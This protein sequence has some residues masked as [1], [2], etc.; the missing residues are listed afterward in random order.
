MPASISEFVYTLL[1]IVTLA[2]YLLGVKDWPLALRTRIRPGIAIIGGLFGLSLGAAYLF[3][4]RG[5]VLSWRFWVEIA[6]C[7]W[8]LAGALIV[9]LAVRR[10]LLAFARLLHER[11]QFAPGVRILLCQALPL[12]LFVLF[13]LPYA[14]AFA[15]V[16]RFKMPIL[17]DP[18]RVWQREF[19]EI[20][21][22]S[23]DGTSLRGW[24][25]PAKPLTSRPEE[26][27]RTLIVC[28]GIAA[29]R[30]LML[31]F[32]EA[33]D[34]LDANVLMFDLR[35]HGESGG[36]S[37]TLGCKEKD[38]V[39]AA[40]AYARRERP[41][42]SKQVI[43]MGVSL[44]AA[45]MAEAAPLAEPPLDAVI[46]D[47][48]FASTADMTHSVLRVFPSCTHPWLLTLGLPMA[49]WHAGCPMMAVR[50][51]ESIRKLRSP[52]LLLHSRGDPLIP[53]EHG[54]R[55]YAN[56]PEPKRLCVFEL[57]GHCDGFFAA[58]ER[59]RAEVMAICA[60]PG[61]CER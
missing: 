54:M 30:S 17:T 9:L 2:V 5:V 59:Y 52:V 7:L 24:W 55:V 61:P 29:N 18:E 42:Q 23:A 10:A 14:I 6:T 32:V 31:P 26:S 36:R 49:D 16:H 38:D 58:K 15:N 11:W 33:G 43:G 13:V 50:P 22:T 60:R 25:I 4:D 1:P 27:P 41:D 35:G 28:H 19:E 47:G 56:A 37:V 34:W 12:T 40:I 20:E 48:C 57:S 8:Y 45:C 53:V 51:E 3:L 21:F 46:L 39:L 44:G